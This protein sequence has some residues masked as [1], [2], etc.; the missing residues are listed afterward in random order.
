M[1]Q[2]GIRRETPSWSLQCF[3]MTEK[4]RSHITED[5]SVE[6][7]M[8]AA[9]VACYISKERGRNRVQVYRPTDAELA[10]RL[11]EMG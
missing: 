3:E 6:E 11:G 9:D 8:R 10:E 7:T 5:S 1:A 2:N 4:D